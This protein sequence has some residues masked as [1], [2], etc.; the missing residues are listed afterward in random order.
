MIS[1][2]ARNG[3][4]SESGSVE[5]NKEEVEALLN[6]KM[7]GKSKFDYKVSRC[8]FSS[9]TCFMFLGFLILG[10][11][12]CWLWKLQGKCEQMT[13]YIK[14]LRMCIK[15]FQELEADYVIKLEKSETAL[16]SLETKCEETGEI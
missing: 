8:N 4:G 7:K 12:I 15:W 2:T 1:E 14:K 10:F 16:K 3:G 6:E 5:F 13:D 9:E 11:L